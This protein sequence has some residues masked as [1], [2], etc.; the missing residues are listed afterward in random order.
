MVFWIMW[1]TFLIL[2][3]VVPILVE[4]WKS[5]HRMAVLRTAIERGQTIDQKLLDAL[6]PRPA[7]PRALL[8]AG[9]IVASV[10]A[11]LAVFSPFLSSLKP[12]LF[13]PVIGASCSLLCIGVGLMIAFRFSGSPTVADDLAQECFLQAWRN[14]NHLKSTGAF[15]GWLRRI[16]VNVWLQHL[17]SCRAEPIDQTAGDSA[18]ADS[19]APTASA[20]QLD[21]AAALLQLQPMARTCIVLFYNEGYTHEEIATATRL[22]LGTVKS[23]IARSTIRLRDLLAAYAP[24]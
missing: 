10:A 6:T 21:L 12:Q 2:V 24:C 14:L 17:R 16:A 4:G 7:N 18:H 19:G 5:K 22:P 8:I 15:G 9:I 20:E 11:A 13:I 1:M 23:H 3:T